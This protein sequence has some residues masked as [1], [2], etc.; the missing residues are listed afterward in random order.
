MLQYLTLPAVPG[1][2]GD[3]DMPLV[4]TGMREKLEA[5]IWADERLEQIREKETLARGLLV[6][7]Y[8]SFSSS[9]GSDRTLQ[10]LTAETDDGCCTARGH[11]CQRAAARSPTGTYGPH[12]AVGQGDVGPSCVRIELSRI[13]RWVSGWLVTSSSF[14]RFWGIVLMQTRFAS[15][16]RQNGVCAPTP[17]VGFDPPTNDRRPARSDPP[18]RRPLASVRATRRALP[19]LSRARPARQHPLR[20]LRVGSRVGALFGHARPRLGRAGADVHRL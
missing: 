6:S 19:R 15:R 1:P 13:D 5:Q 16:G 17:R 10:V 20:A 11:A 7:L 14:L 4:E 18:T 3:A 8:L 2:T 9:S 12:Q